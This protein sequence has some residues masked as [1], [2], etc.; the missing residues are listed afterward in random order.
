M[1]LQAGD[2]RYAHESATLMTHSVMT[3][4]PSGVYLTE[5]EQQTN[6]AENRRL[7][8]LLI[9]LFSRRMSKN[10]AMLGIYFV[11]KPNMMGAQTAL[12]LGFIDA[13]IYDPTTR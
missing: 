8:Q 5:E 9:D 2:V 13:I 12:Q 3:G 7:T 10:P 11:S 1:V 4:Y 6:L